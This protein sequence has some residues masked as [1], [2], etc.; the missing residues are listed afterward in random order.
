MTVRD[1]VVLGALE[2]FFDNKPLL[3]LHDQQHIALYKERHD[4]SASAN[5]TKVFL[6][7]FK[8]GKKM[9]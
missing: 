2:D 3:Y 4:H 8:L 1:L 9:Y 6:A 7:G 5:D